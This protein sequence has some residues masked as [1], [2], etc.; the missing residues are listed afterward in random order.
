MFGLRHASGVDRLRRQ[1]ACPRSSTATGDLFVAWERDDA[2]GDPTVWY[3]VIAAGASE[4]SLGPVMA[5]AG[6][7]AL[8]ALAVDRDRGLAYLAVHDQ[9]LDDIVLIALDDTGELGRVSM[10]ATARIDHSP[11]IAVSPGGGAVGWYRTVSGFRN[12]YLVQ[13][14][15]FDGAVLTPGDEIDLGT[16]QAVGV[17]SPALTHIGDDTFFAAWSEGTAPDFLVKARAVSAR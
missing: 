17:Y 13:P 15:A 5:T 7:S 11:V 1:R 10:G 6:P 2:N 4:F 8:P 3:R 14:F 9:N 16:D 12:R